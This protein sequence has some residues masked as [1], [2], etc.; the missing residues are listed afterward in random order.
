MRACKMAKQEAGNSGTTVLLII[1]LLIWWMM[2][3]AT[4]NPGPAPGPGPKPDDKID[5]QVA[6]ISYMHMD[7]T[8]EQYAAYC[9]AVA[10]SLRTGKIKT[11][12]DLAEVSK[13]L[14]Q[15]AIINGG[16]TASRTVESRLPK[17]EIS[18][19]KAEELAQFFISL[20]EGYSRVA[21]DLK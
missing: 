8:A 3:G 19:E 6:A 15:D 14:T 2:S 21:V 11:G 20:G 16:E 7:T 17:G 5:A 9:S 13:T 1:G 18:S 12:K 10:K 4:P